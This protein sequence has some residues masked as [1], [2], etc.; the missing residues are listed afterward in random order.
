MEFGTATAL[1]VII[2]PENGQKTEILLS[3][4]A[5]HLLE[6]RLAGLRG[7]TVIIKGRPKMGEPFIEEIG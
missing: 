4:L 2:E 6:E 3:D 1:V 7:K 5:I